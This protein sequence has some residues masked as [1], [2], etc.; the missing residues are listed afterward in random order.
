MIVDKFN[1]HMLM[2]A[3]DAR[4]MT[5]ADL[6]DALQVGQG[7]LS[8]Y[9]TGLLEPPKEF[10]DDLVNLLGFLPSFYY[11][12][13]RPY[14]LPPF[15]YRRR[16][17]L[18]AKA[19][20]RIVAEMNIRRLHIAKLL[21]SYDWKT[22]A[23]IPEIDRDEYQGKSKTPWSLEDVARQVREMWMLPSGPISNMVNY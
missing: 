12:T 9:E 3:R 18:S 7:T 4:G 11:E 2:L 15:H 8:K 13:G 6:S 21:R 17:K 19:L 1:H 14:G 16:K 23:F 20:A 5:Q 22:N 10:V